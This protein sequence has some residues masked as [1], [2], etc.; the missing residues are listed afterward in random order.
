MS[1][2]QADSF[3]GPNLI[4]RG[5]LLGKG[6][7]RIEGRLEGEAAIEGVLTVGAP[8]S[9]KGPVR[10]DAVSVAGEIVGCVV[11]TTLVE[12]HAGGRIQGDVEAPQVIMDVDGRVEGNVK[13]TVAGRATLLES[14]YGAARSLG[15]VKARVRSKRAG[16]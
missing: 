9:V 16:S 14:A 13:R 15:K 4:V 1:A 7:V 3:I 2:G 10:A 11:A 12:V 8:G 5:K 6:S